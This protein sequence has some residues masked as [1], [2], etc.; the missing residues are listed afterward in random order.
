MNKKTSTQKMATKAAK[1]LGND[2]SSRIQRSLAASVI[3]QAA[4][5]K[6]T[7]ASLEGIASSVM[8]SPKYSKTTK[9]LAASILSQSDRS[10]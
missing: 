7:G 1:I 10:R 9:S 8:K 4:K 5:H 3:S 2:S 6:T